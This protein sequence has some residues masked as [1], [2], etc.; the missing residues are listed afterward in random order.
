MGANR[1]ESRQV[2]FRV[3][4]DEFAR[5]E[6]MAK[7][8]QMSVP[9]FVKQKAQGARMKPPKVDKAAALEI[10]KQLRSIGNNVNQ[11]TRRAHE[12]GAVAP[13]QLH[14]IQKELQEIWRQLS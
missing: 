11:L 8:L 4:D 3:S 10:A 12:G 6:Q 14:A 2:S 1:K 7:T 5:L 13:D 9:A